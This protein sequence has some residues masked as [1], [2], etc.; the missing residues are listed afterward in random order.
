MNRYYS[1]DRRLNFLHARLRMLCSPLNDHLYSLV[2]VVDNP[3]CSCGHVRENNKHF[4]LECPLY[5][6]ERNNMLRGLD[7]I[8][9]NPLLNNLLYGDKKC[10]EEKNIKAFSIVQEYINNTNRF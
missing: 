1:G 9:F 7:H 5:T 8:E 3:S 6:N 2:H 4:I 10:N